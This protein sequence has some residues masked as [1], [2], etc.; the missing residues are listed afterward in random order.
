MPTLVEKIT[1]TFP[2]TQIQSDFDG[3][4][5]FETPLNEIPANWETFCT[6]KGILTITGEQRLKFLQG[7]A[8]CDTS[9]ITTDK[10]SYGAF[11]NL[12][13]R[14]IANFLAYDDGT[15]SH[16]IMHQGLIPSL[17]DHLTKFAVFFRVTLSN[18]DSIFITG[19]TTD[20]ASDAPQLCIETQESQTS[21]Q[22]SPTRTLLIR[23]LES[24]TKEFI[25]YPLASEALWNLKDHEEG[26]TWEHQPPVKYFYRNCWDWKRLTA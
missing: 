10:A 4:P 16:L 17:I 21:L 24:L 9:K 12:K 23:P 1:T 5:K 18:D 7:Q 22:I 19:Q 2:D 8:T 20:T 6:T 26:I 13:G 15:S 14:A 25:E 11:C 3:A